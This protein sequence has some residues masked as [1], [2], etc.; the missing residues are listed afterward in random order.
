MSLA[1][2]LAKHAAE[3]S[4]GALTGSERMKIQVLKDIATS[5]KVSPSARKDAEVGL[6]KWEKRAQA[7]GHASLAA[8]L[9]VR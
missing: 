1:E 2:I 3:K 6:Q 7:A 5:P 4:R 8:W 9:A